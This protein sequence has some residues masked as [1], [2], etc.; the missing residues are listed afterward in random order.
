MVAPILLLALGALALG[1]FGADIAGALGL[2]TMH[3]A[4]TS[5]LPPLAVVALGIALAWF[6]FGRRSAPRRGFINRVPALETLFVRQWYVDDFYRVV[7]VRLTVALARAL[8]NRPTLILADEPTGNLDE[9]TAH[10][11]IDLIFEICREENSSLVM[12][13][14]NPK[15]AARTDR[16]LLLNHGLLSNAVNC[17]AGT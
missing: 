15:Y 16:Q 17:P 14:H 4:F 12:V 2:Q 11:V 8:M 5:M 9:K 10:G 13:T 1:F 3:H 7:A 6:D